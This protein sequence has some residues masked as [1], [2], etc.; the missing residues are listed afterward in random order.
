MMIMKRL[1][2]SRT[3]KII[4]GVCGGIADYF[5][6]DAWIIRLIWLF[7]GIGF[8]VY[9]ICAIFLPEADD[10]WPPH[11]PHNNNEYYNRPN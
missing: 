6:I 8:I 5:G 2:K 3:N 11:D 4:C 7:T 9:I 1:T 10:P